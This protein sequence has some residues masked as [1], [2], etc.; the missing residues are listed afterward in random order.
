MLLLILSHAGFQLRS[1]DP[2]A[3]KEI[4]LS[5][6]Q[7]ADVERSVATQVTHGVVDKSSLPNAR[8]QSMIA[9][10]TD[11]K[12]NKRKHSD[13]ET[14]EK[15]SFYRKILG[16]IKG[17][18]YQQVNVSSGASSLCL[19]MSLSDIV[20]VETRGRWWSVGSSWIGHQQDEGKLKATQDDTSL[21]QYTDDK[22][23]S[24]EE[25]D[26]LLTLA[27]KNRMNSDIRR[28]TFC[29]IMG[30]HDYEDAFFKLL[31]A[32]MLK[33]VKEKD[34]VRVLLDCCGREK[35]FNPFYSLLGARLCEHS[36]RIKFSFQLAFWDV[37][38]HF[39]YHDQKE[40]KT[41]DARFANNLAKL[42]VHQLK[43][44]FLKLNMLRR[45]EI[46]PGAISELT[47]LF[48][49]VLFTDLFETM[50]DTPRL[51]ELISKGLGK[52]RT[53]DF[54]TDD[55]HVTLEADQIDGLNQSLTTFMLKYLM[56]SPRNIKMSIFE[57]NLKAVL[58]I[59]DGD[60][61]LCG[62]VR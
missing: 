31:K 3:L 60:D 57:R 19:R 47:A 39:N 50:T 58:K 33:G 32:D 52:N 56:S 27:T 15:I 20:N 40:V 51:I 7:R 55:E 49:T 37:F 16:R 44:G 12:N 30:S 11:L 29:I 28:A 9:A 45:L 17:Q 41:K 4:I 24:H 36:T 2:L 25:N 5:V 13:I 34:V 54:Q 59:I 46:T 48:L 8:V 62:F 1:D 6:K 42:L 35:V 21:I 22:I 10:I 38:N 26:K 14:S 23:I 61:S 43:H 18:S 53:H